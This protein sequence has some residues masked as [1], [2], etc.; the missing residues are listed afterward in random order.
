MV[1]R[2]VCLNEDIELHTYQSCG[3]NKHCGN[4]RNFGK[5]GKISFCTPGQSVLGWNSNSQSTDIV[6]SALKNKISRKPASVNSWLG[7]WYFSFTFLQSPHTVQLF[8]ILRFKNISFLSFLFPIHS[9]FSLS[10]FDLIQFETRISNFRYDR[11]MIFPRQLHIQSCVTFPWFEMT[12]AGVFVMSETGPF[13]LDRIISWL[14]MLVVK[15]N[16]EYWI[17]IWKHCCLF[18][19]I[20]NEFKSSM[21]QTVSSFI[22]IITI[23]THEQSAEV[24]YRTTRYNSSELCHIRAAIFAILSSTAKFLYGL[25]LQCQKINSAGKQ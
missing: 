24:N 13:T 10:I 19:V 6:G 23:Y 14:D 22:I 4:N 20:L 2:K 5:S 11:N 9:I 12:L 16:I 18:H 21:I 8:G 15:S 25:Q 3:G 7:Y 1:F 17:S